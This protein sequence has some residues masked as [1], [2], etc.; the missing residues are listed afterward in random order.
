MAQ[1]TITFDSF[2]DMREF[3]EKFLGTEKAPVSLGGNVMPAQAQNVPVTPTAQTALET[4]ITPVQTVPVTPV[5]QPAPASPVQTTPAAQTV[6]VTP[7]QPATS[8]VPTT[9]RSK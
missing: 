5:A 9:E 3:A 4:P 7:V 1:I 2:E 6:P 8:P